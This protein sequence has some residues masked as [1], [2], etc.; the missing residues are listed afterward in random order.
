MKAN[1]SFTDI[2]DFPDPNS[3]PSSSMFVKELRAMIDLGGVPYNLLKGIAFKSKKIVNVKKPPIILLPG[4]A[5][6][7]R[8]LK[9]LQFHLRSLGYTAEG[10]GL[11]FNMAGTNLPH[12]LEQL[13][14]SWDVE[15]YDGYTPETYRGEGGVPYLCDRATDQILA[16][17]KE[18]GEPVVLIGWSLGGYVAREVAR[19]L[20]AHVAKVITLGAPVIGGPKYTRA[21]SFFKKKGFDMEWIESEVEKRNRK[22]ITQ[23]IT[24]IFSKTDAVVDWRAA[25]DKVSPNVAHIQIDA[26]HLGM[27]FNANIW[28]LIELSLEKF[29]V[30]QSAT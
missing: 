29:Q 7:E 12:T 22:P 11:G 23:P 3:A 28:K 15:Y 5:S 1:L 27:G 19:E 6:D 25:L 20:P 21:A 8:Y 17:S 14:P 13:A 24:A 2:T 4:F 30:D 9:P 26:A 10:W 18:I 16:R